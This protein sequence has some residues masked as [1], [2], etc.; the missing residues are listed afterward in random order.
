MG[1]SVIE[2]TASM[3]TDKKQVYHDSKTAWVTL[4]TELRRRA[5]K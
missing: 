1:H 5:A 3:L 2:E 4:A